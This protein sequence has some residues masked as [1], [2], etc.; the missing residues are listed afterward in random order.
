[1]KKIKD[2]QL[3]N[4]PE[5]HTR[6][7]LF[8][9]DKGTI[10][11]KNKKQFITTVA[12]SLQVTFDDGSVLNL[13]AP[14]FY[15]FDG[16]TIPFGIGKGDMRLQIPALFHDIMC[17]EKYWTNYDRKLADTIFKE[18]LIRCGVNRF[19]AEYMFLHVEVYQKIFCDWRN[20]NEQK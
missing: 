11:K 20:P 18:C 1:M 6:S 10:K 2:I 19:I 17:D 8:F 16:A 14:E 13:Y 9:D 4:D 5:I 3:S 7:V 12:S 15:T